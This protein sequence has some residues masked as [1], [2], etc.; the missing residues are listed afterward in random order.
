MYAAI[1]DKDD[2]DRGFVV[3]LAVIV[4]HHTHRFGFIVD[5]LANFPLTPSTVISVDVVRI[6]GQG[7]RG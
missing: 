7:S 1:A 2:V 3:G 4:H 6:V 5:T